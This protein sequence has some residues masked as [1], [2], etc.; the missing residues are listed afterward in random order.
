MVM[1][2]VVTLKFIFT[3]ARPQIKDVEVPISFVMIFR[4]VL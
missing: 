4:S 2:S 3:V 1:K